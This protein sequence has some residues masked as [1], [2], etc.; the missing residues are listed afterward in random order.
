MRWIEAARC[1]LLL[2]AACSSKA[3]RGSHAV[4]QRQSL[5]CS[6]PCARYG[7][8]RKIHPFHAA[9]NEWAN[10]ADGANG[11]SHTFTSA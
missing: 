9:K 3:D 2:L 7:D 4:A 8:S 6:S 1:L 10:A 11:L 5:G